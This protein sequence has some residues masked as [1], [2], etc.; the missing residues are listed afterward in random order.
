MSP[1][2]IIDAWER[3]D[4]ALQSVEKE[5]TIR[6]AKP[7]DE[8][9]IHTDEAGIGRRLLAHDHATVEEVTVLDADDTRQRKSPEEVD[10]EDEPVAIRCR[11][12]VGAV[13]V[14]SS[15]RKTSQHADVVTKRVL[16]DGGRYVL[17]G[18]DT[19]VEDRDKGD[20]LV[21]LNTHP[22]TTAAARTLDNDRTV[23]E[24]N[25][26]YDPDAPVVECCYVDEIVDR[27]DEWRD[28]SDLRAAVDS[29]ELSKYDFP[30]DR[31]TVAEEVAQ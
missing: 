5:T 30:V 25:P 12:P 22:T 27:V 20:R 28:V 13:T 2:E 17:P 10:D 1:E 9:V 19:V 11:L 24:L 8:A 4:P 26:E 16:A 3:G 14:G 7:D 15:P 6:W 31:L 29:G 23:A 18:P 21:V